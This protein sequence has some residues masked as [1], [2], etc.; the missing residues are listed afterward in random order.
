MNSDV[1]TLIA[2][3][4][5]AGVDADLIGR[6]AEALAGRVMVDAPAAF[7]DE[8]RS[9]GAIRQ[10]RYRAR[11]TAAKQRNRASQSVTRD[12]TRYA[13]QDGENRWQNGKE[14]EF[15]GLFAN[16]GND[17]R[18]NA[19]SQ[20]VTGDV[21]RYAEGQKEKAPHTPLEK[22]SPLKEKTPKGVQKKVPLIAGNEASEARRRAGDIAG[23]SAEFDDQFWPAYPQKVAKPAALKAF[24][25]ARTRAD[26]ETILAGLNRYVA[27]RDDRPWCNPATWLNQDRWNDAPVSAPQPMPRSPPAFRENLQER[28]Q[29]ISRTMRGEDDDGT[30]GKIIDIGRR[31]YR[32]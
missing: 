2:D 9:A 22:N 32:A 24:M 5:R 30:G 31:D 7:E 19:A 14:P 8:A 27:K 20:G 10:E 1:A 26:L 4:V 17:D 6:T 21:T 18:R 29:R 28:Q 23:L 3:M 16:G 13:L 12:V 15:T 25:R 11:K